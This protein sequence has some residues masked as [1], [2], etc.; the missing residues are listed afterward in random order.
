M[1]ESPEFLAEIYLN[2]IQDIYVKK[3]KVTKSK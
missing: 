2:T 3:I 1:Q